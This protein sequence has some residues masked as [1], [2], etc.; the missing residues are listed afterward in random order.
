MDRA[1]GGRY[2]EG[3]NIEVVLRI[4]QQCD[5][6]AMLQYFLVTDTNNEHK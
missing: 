6:D 5:N 3:R 2:A 4:M 1:Q